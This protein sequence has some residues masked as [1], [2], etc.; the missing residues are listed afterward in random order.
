VGALLAGLVI[1]LGS[2]VVPGPL[3]VL[4]IATTLRRGIRSGLLVACG[5]L[6]SDA[7]II[8]VSL[9]VVSVLPTG[10]RLALGIAGSVV[11]AV[12]GVETLRAARRAD[13][14]AMRATVEPRSRRTALT[15]HPLVQATLLNLLNPAPWLF[16][17]TAGAAMLRDYWMSSPIEAVAFLT[18]FYVGLVGSKMAVVAGVALGQRWLTTPTY[19]RVLIACGLALLIL[20]LLL[21]ARTIQDVFGS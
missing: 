5:P 14:E 12:F 7:F 15:S 2:G 9:T 21:A 6:V 10:A 11:V 16:W 17:F 18:T 1:G 4:A 8:A 13:V 19:R 3:V 20:A